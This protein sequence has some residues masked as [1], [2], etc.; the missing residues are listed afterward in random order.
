MGIPKKSRNPPFCLAR[1]R[2]HLSVTQA[3]VRLRECRRKNEVAGQNSPEKE[4]NQVNYL[5]KA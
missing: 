1:T 5:C 2:L 4:E 3:Q